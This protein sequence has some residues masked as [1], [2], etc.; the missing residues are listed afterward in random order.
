[1]AAALTTA[2]IGAVCVAC[3]SVT[4]R[5]IEQPMIAFGERLRVA[6]T[7]SPTNGTEA[8]GVPTAAAEVTTHAA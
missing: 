8:I 6:A 5:L 4:Y 3:A 7:A 2:A 1:M